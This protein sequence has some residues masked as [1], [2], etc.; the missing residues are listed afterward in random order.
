MACRETGMR[1]SS[2]REILLPEYSRT[3]ASRH[4]LVERQEKF[5]ESLRTLSSGLA[6]TAGAISFI[7]PLGA[8]TSISADRS[9]LQ[10]EENEHDVITS[11]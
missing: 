7:S 2:A 4:A 6:L 9:V 5:V 3:A 11:A 1:D 10:E 8:L